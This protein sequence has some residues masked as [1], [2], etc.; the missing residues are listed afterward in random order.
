VPPERFGFDTS[1]FD[2]AKVATAICGIVGSEKK[3]MTQCALMCHFVRE[4]KRGVEIRSRCW[5][6][7]TLQLKGIKKGSNLNRL[8]NNKM[9]KRWIIPS[10]IGYA[11]CMHSA[12]EYNNLA[13]ILPELYSTYA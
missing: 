4:V 7:H 1:Q 2:K 3:K 5:I 10:K 13:V 6:G 8:I 9:I 11:Y 12:Q